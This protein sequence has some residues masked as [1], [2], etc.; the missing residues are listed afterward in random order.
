MSA[1]S[2]P[3]LFQPIQIG[4]MTLQHRLVLTPLTR[5]RADEEHTPILPIA[6]DYYT[7]RARAPG[8]LLITEATLV[9]PKAGGTNNIPG[10]WSDTQIAAWKKITTS[11][12]ERGSFI[13]L[14]MWGLGRAALQDVLSAEGLDYV[15][16]S[17]VALSY[18]PTPPPRPLT[19]PEIKEYV[20]LF[21]KAASNAVNLA[22]FDGVE[23]H[24][25]N[26]YLIDQFFQDVSNKRTDQYGGSPENRA[27]FAL[28]VLE[29]VSKE[30]GEDRTAVRISPWSRFQEMGMVNPKP[31]YSYFV[32]QLKDRLP[33][34]AYLH[35]IEPR[36]A[37]GKDIGLRPVADAEDE[38]NNHVEEEN[39]F[40]RRIWSPKPFISAGGYTRDLALEAA[41]HGDI[42]AVGRYFLANPDLPLRWKDNLPLNA[43][44]R[45]TFY[46]PGDASGKGYSDY[47]FIDGTTRLPPLIAVTSPLPYPAGE[48]SHGKSSMPSLSHHDDGVSCMA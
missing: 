47:P 15:S 39:N 40:L 24:G 45:S 28:E 29:A 6:Q 48:V 20:Q 16:A 31:T 25:A 35:A 32:S 2:S 17:D 33:N 12:H 18:Q 11:V 3:K 36:V 38:G 5:F 42:I 43:Y 10:I 21:A 7:Q 27:R 30:I 37:D 8:T 9:A 26:G 13:Y 23:I 14:Q 1:P 4:R 41:E 22:G 19:I 34:L 46:V 44:D